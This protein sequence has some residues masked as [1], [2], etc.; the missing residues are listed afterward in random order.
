ML[1]KTH[2]Q[3]KSLIYYHKTIIFLNLFTLYYQAP[4]VEG[5]AKMLIPTYREFSPLL[6]SMRVAFT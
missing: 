3:K 5:G 1:E 2:S 6:L 4:R